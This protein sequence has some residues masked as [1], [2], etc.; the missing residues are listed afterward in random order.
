MLLPPPPPPPSPTPTHPPTSPESCFDPVIL[1]RLVRRVHNVSSWPSP[2]SD[3]NNCPPEG[4]Y[5]TINEFGP[6]PNRMNANAPRDPGPPIS[7]E[8]SFVARNDTTADRSTGRRPRGQDSHCLWQIGEGMSQPAGCNAGPRVQTTPDEY[9][10]LSY[11]PVQPSATQQGEAVVY[12]LTGVFTPS[13]EEAEY[14]QL[15]HCVRR[16]Q[17]RV[18]DNVYD[19]A[20][21]VKKS[22][23]RRQLCQ[24]SWRLCDLRQMIGREEW[25]LLSALNVLMLPRWSRNTVVDMLWF[26]M[27]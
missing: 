27:W 17:P 9:Q 4:E 26:L 21:Y 1:K 11:R 19:T 15:K 22:W 25:T 14:H 2:G 8:T 7:E 5:C 3:H 20:N 23:W 12:N 13:G 6:R 10:S 16:Q 24:K 18:I